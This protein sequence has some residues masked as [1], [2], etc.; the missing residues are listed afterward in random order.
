MPINR[1]RLLSSI[2][3]PF[4]KSRKPLAEVCEIP[5]LLFVNG[6]ENIEFTERSIER[7]RM[8]NLTISLCIAGCD[9]HPAKAT[10]AEG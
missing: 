2:R 4:V 5:D 1:R 9:L 8:P 7:F 10:G 6:G 3:E